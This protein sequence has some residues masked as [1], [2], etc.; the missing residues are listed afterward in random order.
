MSDHDEEVLAATGGMS[1]LQENAITDLERR[2]EGKK[3]HILEL[4]AYIDDLESQVPHCA[5]EKPSPTTSVSSSLANR[6]T[7]V[8][9]DHTS[10]LA[11]FDKELDVVVEDNRALHLRVTELEAKEQQMA[12]E[13]VRLQQLVLEKGSALGEKCQECEVLRGELI[14]L[15]PTLRSQSK[16]I[17]SLTKEVYALEQEIPK[18]DFQEATPRTVMADDERAETILAVQEGHQEFQ[19]LTEEKAALCTQLEELMKLLASQKEV[20]RNRD[21]KAREMWRCDLRTVTKK[22]FGLEE[23]LQT[24]L[25]EKEELLRS[26]DAAL[27]RMSSLA[28]VRLKQLLALPRKTVLRDAPIMESEKENEK[29][30]LMRAAHQK[31]IAENAKL[32]REVQ[33]WKSLAKKGEGATRTAS[34]STAPKQKYDIVQERRRNK[35]LEIALE[36]QK[37]LRLHVQ[38]GVTA[39]RELL[40]RGKKELVDKQRHIE[41]L[42]EQLAALTGGKG[43]HSAQVE[44]NRQLLARTH[45]L[46]N[47]QSTHKEQLL[48]K[49]KLLIN[50]KAH[51]KCPDCQ[52]FVTRANERFR[53]M[54]AFQSEQQQLIEAKNIELAILDRRLDAYFKRFQL[55]QKDIKEKELELSGRKMLQALDNARVDAVS[56][57]AGQDVGTRGDAPPHDA[58]RPPSAERAAYATNE[59]V[60]WLATVPYFAHTQTPGPERLSGLTKSCA[61]D[62]TNNRYAPC[63]IRREDE[64]AQHVFRVLSHRILELEQI[65]AQNLNTTSATAQ[66]F[67]TRVAALLTAAT[68][69][70]HRMDSAT[71]LVRPFVNE[72]TKSSDME[73]DAKD[74]N[75]NNKEE[76]TITT[77]VLSV[78][79]AVTHQLGTVLEAWHAR[80]QQF[81]TALVNARRQ[82][83]LGGEKQQM[84]LAPTAVPD[85]CGAMS[86]PESGVEQ[87]AS[88]R[89]SFTRQ[90]MRRPSRRATQIDIDKLEYSIRTLMNDVEECL[91]STGK[92]GNMSI[93]EEDEEENEEEEEARDTNAQLGRQLFRRSSAQL[94]RVLEDL[95][96]KQEELEALALEAQDDELDEENDAHTEQPGWAIREQERKNISD[97]SALLEDVIGELT[98]EIRSWLDGEDEAEEGD[99]ALPH[100]TQIENGDTEALD[101]LLWLMKQKQEKFEYYAQENLR[102]DALLE[103]LSAQLKEDE[104]AAQSDT[105]AAL[106]R[107]LAE[108]DSQ[109]RTME[110]QLT[111]EAAR[112]H[113]G[114]GA[115]SHLE[116]A[117]DKPRSPAEAAR[118][119][120]NDVASES[121]QSAE[122]KGDAPR[123]AEVEP[124][125][126]LTSSLSSHTLEDRHGDAART[127]P[128]VVRAQKPKAP[129]CVTFHDLMDVHERRACDMLDALRSK[130]AATAASSDTPARDAEEWRN[131][132]TTAAVS[133]L[134]G[135]NTALASVDED[136]DTISSDDAGVEA[137]QG[138]MMAQM[139]QMVDKLEEQQALEETLTCTL[140]GREKEVEE[141]TKEVARL[142]ETSNAAGT[143]IAR[144]EG[145][146]DKSEEENVRL[147]QQ[148]EKCAADNQQWDE[149]LKDKQEEVSQ[150]KSKIDEYVAIADE[151]WEGKI[152]AKEE[153]NSVLQ[154]QIKAKEEEV[155]ALKGQ[156]QDNEDDIASPMAMRARTDKRLHLA[157]QPEQKE[158]SFHAELE[159]H[160]RALETLRA[161]LASK[162]NVINALHKETES[163]HDQVR[164][165]Q[166]HIGDK[167]AEGLAMLDER[168]HIWEATLQ[169]K[170]QECTRIAHEE[171]QLAR[172]IDHLVATAKMGPSPQWEARLMAKEDEVVGL[173]NAIERLHEDVRSTQESKDA[174]AVEMEKK[175]VLVRDME[176]NEQELLRSLKSNED[177]GRK[178]DWEQADAV[179]VAERAVRV[180]MQEEVIGPLRLHVARSERVMVDMEEEM[181]RLCASHAAQCASHVD[182][183][184]ALQSHAEELTR[185]HNEEA[186]A[187]ALAAQH[188]TDTRAE[189]DRELGAL[190]V[191]LQEAE[192]SAASRAA[193]AA[194]AVED[195]RRRQQC[196]EE[197]DD[198]LQR[199]EEALADANRC[200][201]EKDVDLARL[202][203]RVGAT[204]THASIHND[205]IERIRVALEDACAQSAEKD[206]TIT[207]LTHVV[208]ENRAVVFAKDHDIEQLTHVLHEHTVREEETVRHL[209]A[210]VEDMRHCV[211]DKDRDTAHVRHTLA[212]MEQ[213]V[214]EKDDA[215]RVS[216]RSLEHATT[217]LE[218]AQMECASLHALTES[219]R[220]QMCAFPA[221]KEEAVLHVTA[222]AAS[223][224][225]GMEEKA[226]DIDALCP[227]SL[228]GM[229]T[230]SSDKYAATQH[231]AI[232][233][234]DPEEDDNRE[235]A[236]LRRTIE[237]GK[238]CSAEKYEEIR[239]LQRTCDDMVVSAAAKDGEIQVLCAKS[240][241][242]V[243]RAEETRA[244]IAHLQRT[245]EDA[246][247]AAGEREACM[248][249]LQQSFDDITASIAAKDADI[250]R[251]HAKDEENALRAQEMHAE[252][253]HL[254][255]TID[256]AT[257]AAAQRETCMRELQRSFDDITASIAAK[258]A[259]VIRLHTKDEENALRAQETHAEISH[260]QCTLDNVA[261][262]TTEKDNNI[263]QLQR[264]LEDM[265]ISGVAKDSEI[266]HCSDNIHSLQAAMEDAS[267]RTRAQDAEITRLKHTVEDMVCHAAE[268]DRAVASHAEQ[269]AH[270]RERVS[271]QLHRHVEDVTAQLGKKDD[272]DQEDKDDTRPSLPGLLYC[273]SNDIATFADS[274]DRLLEEYVR[275]T[276]LLAQ[277]CERDIITRAQHDMDIARGDHERLLADHVD[278]HSRHIEASE[279][280]ASHAAQALVRTEHCVVSLNA[281]IARVEARSADMMDKARADKERTEHLYRSEAQHLEDAVETMKAECVTAEDSSRTLMHELKLRASQLEWSEQHTYDLYTEQSTMRSTIEDTIRLM[282]SKFDDEVRALTGEVERVH[283]H[284]ESMDNDLRILA[285]E[286]YALRDDLLNAEDA[287]AKLHDAYTQRNAQILLWAMKKP[288]TQLLRRVQWRERHC[289]LQLLWYQWVAMVEERGTTAAAARHALVVETMDSRVCAIEGGAP[290]PD[291]GASS[292]P[293]LRALSP[294]QRLRRDRSVSPPV[295][296]TN[297]DSLDLDAM[298]GTA[299]NFQVVV[300]CRPCGSGKVGVDISDNRTEVRVPTEEPYARD[301]WGKV[302]R[303]DKA[304]SSVSQDSLY[305]ECVEPLVSD[306]LEGYNTTIICY[307]QTGSGK[308]YTIE[309]PMDNKHHSTLGRAH[310]RKVPWG[311]SGSSDM[312]HSMVHVSSERGILPRIFQTLF[313]QTPLPAIRLGHIEIYNESVRDVLNEEKTPKIRE[314]KGEVFME[315]LTWAAINSMDDFFQILRLARRRRAAFATR[316]NPNSSRSHSIYICQVAIPAAGTCGTMHVVDL[317]GSEKVS[318]SSDQPDHAISTAETRHIN[319]SL[320]NLGNVVN[321]LSAQK[322]H[323]PY[324]DSKLTRVLQDALGGNAKTLIILNCDKDVEHGYET[325]STLRFGERA[326]SITNYVKINRTRRSQQ[327]RPAFPG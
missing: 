128:G 318:R 61:Q 130:A 155:A 23:Q 289:I 269:V 117:Q 124:T 149:K 245:I 270:L 146:R 279:V 131:N 192:E 59:Y 207:R 99:A 219:L 76:D 322:E 312:A 141:L 50:H 114:E 239:D 4:L 313:Q 216:T 170:E 273:G 138:K 262:S 171:A 74:G 254:Q 26:K 198:V 184:R 187:F 215:I 231:A 179:V 172:Q 308:T 173:W 136:D 189:K 122:L 95:R 249:E 295:R 77:K 132:G 209:H 230:S 280:D 326:R 111:H 264:A 6:T 79:R 162:D 42:T 13:N 176:R 75:S 263:R 275:R 267:V 65:V 142:T 15:K 37:K 82:E 160:A 38:K 135:G 104:L 58:R 285:D 27:V 293:N 291:G 208:E 81:D 300:R 161:E 69:L 115:G 143:N 233:V 197:K 109:L 33:H 46:I 164:D 54:E 28:S 292:P 8:E 57:A 159:Q 123:R 140:K 167:E 112:W 56:T 78:I 108:K 19:R 36:A 9:R 168:E 24:S 73:E 214:R 316:D 153:E 266:V 235:M 110:L 181:T 303:F 55:Q 129:K 180:S 222:P 277:K 309:G 325:K 94:E 310:D 66:W 48:Q 304:Y 240:E 317:A 311:G 137:F 307:G 200:V 67:T 212:A 320:A 297:E 63:T 283:R 5:S 258:D 281:D 41:D 250:L 199:V 101:R 31:T 302:F 156:T 34:S 116:C 148:L 90:S 288:P 93:D 232:L 62:T 22:S 7:V 84:M 284:K 87:F 10:L 260:L 144:D 221:E 185:Q 247:K 98:T 272:D 242:M 21:A 72:F 49:R 102:K 2:L 265:T 253:L 220:A 29:L 96:A 35:E 89:V 64:D 271:A 213:E 17:D 210:Q 45:E 327:W 268:K 53:Q 43:S 203:D 227:Q 299:V 127:V 125:T 120:K 174:L 298:P 119:L 238:P 30:L 118:A 257:N 177:R 206:G 186:A 205:D 20:A 306:V 315:E 278:R 166:V 236:H 223:L 290:G 86:P 92:Y 244:E 241:D 193:A 133:S 261:H 68:A 32:T 256:D 25:R 151:L 234:V 183:H 165:A 44:A 83:K 196:V 157:A 255:R 182:E 91:N 105:V 12:K 228:E 11:G 97:P 175:R 85:V 226:K 319:R 121:M 18:N 202:Q 103:Q 139:Q 246:T 243:V 169:R 314:Y 251:L 324:R 224:A 14:T 252:I 1:Q 70:E 217:H 286:K 52:I 188:H 145:D 190:R 195:T 248:R 88:Q 39:D 154:V 323:V 163:L 126:E 194:A 259:D 191:H 301:P 47:T 218:E 60:K 106:E 107:Q 16:Q 51:T 158:T 134:R 201:A 178:R 71:R 294:R 211:D 287:H 150:L 296:G 282:R 274:Y 321:A 225:D 152:R 276:S 113:G 237:D 147:R 100:S 80:Q 305:H 40:A 204:D 3:A 229:R